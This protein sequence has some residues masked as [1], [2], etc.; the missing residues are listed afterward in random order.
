MLERRE[1][2]R[3]AT[4]GHLPQYPS[5]VV[6]EPSPRSPLLSDLEWSAVA[7]ALRDAD[8]CGCVTNAKEGAS[9]LA[10]LTRNLFGWTAPNGLA[11]PRLEA[12]RRFACS[13]HLGHEPLDELEAELSSHGFNPAQI[14][15]IATL[16]A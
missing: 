11:D 6:M 15:A 8:D 16:S 1:D 9:W 4:G 10:R 14:S 12:V 3:G 5:E 2:K 7:I 13:A